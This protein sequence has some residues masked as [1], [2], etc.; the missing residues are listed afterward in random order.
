MTGFALATPMPTARYYH[1]SVALGSTIYLVG[2]RNDS[3]SVLALE[4]YDT[5]AGT[6]S[7]RAP[8]PAAIDFAFGTPAAALGGKILAF[9]SGQPTLIYDPASNAWTTGATGPTFTLTTPAV[10]AGGRIYLVSQSGAVSACDAT[11]ACLQVATLPDA[12]GQFALAEA[13]GK[14]YVIGGVAPHNIVGNPWGLYFDTI[15]VFD[16]ASA[17]FTTFPARLLHPVHLDSAAEVSGRLCVIGPTALSTVPATPQVID[18]VAGT[19]TYDPV[20]WGGLR[21]ATSS[22]TVGGVLFLTGGRDRSAGSVESTAVDAYVPA[23]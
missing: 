12:R 21:Y 10:S 22:A 3:G 14:V 20:G 15:L 1:A 17:A 11:G 23:P 19:V 9:R 2:G 8:L 16:P 7:T 5:V 18:P 4:A 13:G 6:W